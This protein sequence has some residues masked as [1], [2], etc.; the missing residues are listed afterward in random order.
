MKNQTIPAGFGYVKNQTI[1]STCRCGYVKNQAIQAAGCGYVEETALFL[2]DVDTL[3]TEQY[4][5]ECGYV[6]K[7]IISARCEYGKNRTILVPTSVSCYL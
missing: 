6:T 7:Q 2:L 5:L 1:P 3:R 4:L